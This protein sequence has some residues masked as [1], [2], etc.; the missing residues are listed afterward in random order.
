[1][2]SGAGPHRAVNPRK[3]Q[4]Y[5]KSSLA[6]YSKST[7]AFPAARTSSQNASENN[8]ENI[9]SGGA[10]RAPPEKYF[11]FTPPT[12]FF[13]IFLGAGKAPSEAGVLSGV[14]SDSSP[15]Y[16]LTTFIFS[17]DPQ[18]CGDWGITSI[19][20]RSAEPRK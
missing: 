20:H 10:L 3:S 14:L 9:T 5:S 6:K 18:S 1:M 11:Y 2:L 12:T 8:S 4:K 13:T 16:F 19:L 7:L 17:G 15:E